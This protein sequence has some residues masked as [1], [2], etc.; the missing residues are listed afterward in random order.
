M[1]QLEEED[2]KLAMKIKLKEKSD[3]GTESVTPVLCVDVEQLI[4][5]RYVWSK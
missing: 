5:E 4:K 1:F 3:Q 2:A